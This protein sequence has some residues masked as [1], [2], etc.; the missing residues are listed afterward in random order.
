ML[1]KSILEFLTLTCLWLLWD[2]P[3]KAKS[4]T[5]FL[6]QWRTQKL[7]R[8]FCTAKFFGDF[9]RGGGLTIWSLHSPLRPAPG[10]F[11]HGG[12]VGLKPR[13]ISSLYVKSKTLVIYTHFENWGIWCLKWRG[14]SELIQTVSGRRQPLSYAPGPPH[15]A[16]CTF[17]SCFFWH[18]TSFGNCRL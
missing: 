1:G 2:L 7:R 4:C 5:S 15:R 13:L 6:H 17:P 11:S 3:R 9:W 8:I 12:L 14:F 16:L 10:I 18:L